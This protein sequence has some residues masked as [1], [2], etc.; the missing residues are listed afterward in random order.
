MFSDHAMDIC[1]GFILSYTVVNLIHVDFVIIYI[2]LD[3]F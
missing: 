3:L 2:L 1:C